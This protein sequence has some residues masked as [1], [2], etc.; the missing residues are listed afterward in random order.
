ML[1]S[2]Y[3]QELESVRQNL[4]RMG[5]TT[6]SLFAEA[7]NAIANPSPASSARASELEAQTDHQH[8]LIHDQCLNIITL[9]APVASDARL[10]TGVLDA[11][12]DLE[13]IGDYAY[14]TVTLSSA[15]R[16][17]PPSQVV[18]QMSAVGA[19]IQESLSAAIDSWRMLDRDR[20]F[21]VRPR[22]AAIRAECGALYEKLSQLTSSAPGNAA[23]YVDLMLICRHLERILRHA[24]S[25][26][27][28]AADAAPTAQ[29]A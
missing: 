28:Q 18:S 15:L 3:I 14:E 6:L 20:A 19:K 7:L 23:S 27:D 21:S 22:E 4:V 24:A 8:R 9:Q 17:R 10:V 5:E 29:T 12:V 1:R 26:A 16:G 2:H 25:V 13:L 11:I